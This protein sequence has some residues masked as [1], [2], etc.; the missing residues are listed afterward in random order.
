MSHLNDTHKEKGHRMDTNVFCIP[1]GMMETVEKLLVSKAKK[2]AKYGAHLSYSFG[3]PYVK[4]VEVY[5]V[6]YAT[7]TKGSIGTAHYHV[8]D[9]TITSEVIKLNGYEVVAMIEHLNGGNV[10]KMAS[11]IKPEW[12]TMPPYCEHCRGNHGQRTTFIVRHESGVEKQV[13]KTC[14]KDYCGINPQAI[15]WAHQIYDAIEAY[16][17]KSFDFHASGLPQA[18]DTAKVLAL[19]VEV[20]NQQGYINSG[21]ANCNRE[22]LYKLYKDGAEP[23]AEAT[24]KASEIA[25]GIAAMSIEDANKALLG[26]V[27]SLVKSGYC[28]ASH[29][30]FLAY[31]P[32]AYKDYLDRL[33]AKQSR[34]EE[35]EADRATSKYVGEVGERMTFKVKSFKFVTSWE[36]QY[37][38]THLYKFTTTD[39]NV[40]M[41]FASAVF[42]RWVDNGKTQHFAEYEPEEVTEIVATVKSHNERDGVKQTIITRVK[43]KSIKG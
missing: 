7:Q 1:E 6:D 37:G 12:L 13:G 11:E 24:A 20:Y 16:E 27:Q 17:V 3:E 2:A 35:L 39:G 5:K 36:T 43:V 19:A 4:E 40:L 38:T 23:S 31:A 32:K 28:K 22:A 29:F 8:V 26:N 15:G 25:K 18:H 10:V 30:G 9:L 33:K 21:T 34:E 41:W 42:G 14:L